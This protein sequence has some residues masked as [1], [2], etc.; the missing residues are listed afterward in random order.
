[1]LWFALSPWPQG[2]DGLHLSRRANG[3]PNLANLGSLLQSTDC[4]KEARG[5]FFS[6][7]CRF[8]NLQLQL[9][10]SKK[11]EI[12]KREISNRMCRRSSWAWRSQTKLQ[13]A[14]RMLCLLWWWIVCIKSGTV[15]VAVSVYCSGEKTF[16]GVCQKIFFNRGFL[17]QTSF[18]CPPSLL[19][20]AGA[21]RRIL[22][23][24]R[25]ALATAA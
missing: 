20:M 16:L 19:R 24:A 10:R 3:I 2:L 6:S 21:Q 7:W 23:G 8:R 18:V 13:C 17:N 4:Q 1:M 15:A 5:V 22:P 12:N 25:P 11:Q 14:R 9:W